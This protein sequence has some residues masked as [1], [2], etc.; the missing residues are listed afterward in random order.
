MVS[1]SSDLRI[2]DSR[3]MARIYTVGSRTVVT[4]DWTPAQQSAPR[5][6]YE[7]ARPASLGLGPHDGN[8]L[9]EK[10]V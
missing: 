6:W 7:P 10:F 4:F 1:S 2:Q 9:R 5:P 8:A 3:Q